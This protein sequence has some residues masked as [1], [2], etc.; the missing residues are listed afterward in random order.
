MESSMSLEERKEARAYAWAYF[1]LHAD[2]RMKIFN[3]FIV[4]AGIILGALSAMRGVFPEAK[5][6]AGFPV[7]LVFVSFVFWRLEVRTRWLV[8][9]G[10]TALRFLDEQWSV[11]PLPDGTPH[12]MR[13][14]DRDEHFRSA[15][16]S[17]WWTKCKIPISYGDCFRLTY[18]VS[19]L[20]GVI[21]AVWIIGT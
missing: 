1:A 16:G 13:L 10:E 19:G 5:L 4:L 2:Q 20:I 9:N 18:L 11:G 14:F 12:F 21:L 15:L 8:R 3:F 6:L 7:L 17:R